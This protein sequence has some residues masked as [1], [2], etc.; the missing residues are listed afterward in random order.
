MPQFGEFS[1]T[2]LEALRHYLRARAR[3]DLQSRSA[4]RPEMAK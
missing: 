2:E 4:A 1:D 3:K